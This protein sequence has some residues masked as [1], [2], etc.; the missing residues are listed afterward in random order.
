MAGLIEYTRTVLAGESSVIS[1]RGKFVRVKDTTAPIRVTTTQNQ[2]GGA[3]GQ[4]YTSTMT[5]FEKLYTDDIFDQVAIDNTAEGSADVVVTLQVGVGDF[6]SDVISRTAAAAFGSTLLFAANAAELA[7]LSVAG[8][9]FC[10]LAVQGPDPLKKRAIV[11]LQYL[12]PTAAAFDPTDMDTM[13]Q[14]LPAIHIFIDATDPPPDGLEGIPLTLPDAA[15]FYAGQT[16]A[17]FEVTGGIGVRCN[18][19]YVDSVIFSIWN[20]TYS[21]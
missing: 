13:R 9:G 14:S 1:A 19:T 16:E 8:D 2:L 3:S 20:E 18:P 6:Q 5:K 10:T 12:K 7:A 4:S 17:I 11:R 15:G 21:Q